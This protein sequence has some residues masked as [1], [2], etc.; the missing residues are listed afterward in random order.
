MPEMRPGRPGPAQTARY[1]A[2][3]HHVTIPAG[4]PNRFL[5]GNLPGFSGPFSGTSLLRGNP[6]RGFPGPLPLGE[7]QLR[8]PEGRSHERFLPPLLFPLYSPT[9]RRPPGALACRLGLPAGQ[10]GRPGQGPPKVREHILALRP[11]GRLRL[12]RAAWVPVELSR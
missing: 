4:F 11:V 12:P 5:R 9:P 1:C 3:N 10:R 2:Q 8:W 7:G 6:S